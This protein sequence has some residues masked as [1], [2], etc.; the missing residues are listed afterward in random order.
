MTERSVMVTGAAGYVGRLTVE[1]LAGRREGIRAV[2]AVDVR[3]VPPAERLGGVTYVTADVSADDLSGVMREHGIDT[4]VHL[5]SIVRVPP[6][7]PEDLAYRVDVVGTRKVLD[8]CLATG[9]HKLV[10]TTSGAAYGYHADNP[11]WLRED[12][13]L[14]GNERFLYS[15]HKKLIEEML[16]DCRR[17]HPE[18]R[19]LV[20][21][22]GT[23]VGEGTSSPVTDLFEGPVI[24]GI[25]GSDSPFVFVWDRDL[26]EIILLG[27]LEDRE[28]IYNVAGDGALTGRAIAR[29]LGKPYVPVPTAVVETALRVLRALG[30]T[31]HGPEQVDFLRYRPV[32]SNR[33]LV[34]E[35]G[36]RPLSSAEA[37]DQWARSRGRG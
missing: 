15:H 37:F 10:V 11:P 36:Y 34:E 16:A 4:V 20:L 12:H 17:D 28:G 33:R 7:A 19:Q 31:A 9:A 23:V 22:P 13:P 29:R 5:A 21:R 6:G 26:V 3:E 25:R 14:R 8:A 1:A 35:L 30:R 18:L 27:V 32:L 2:V 24:L